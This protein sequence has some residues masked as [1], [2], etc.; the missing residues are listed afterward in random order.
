VSYCS[1]EGRWNSCLDIR[2]GPF[3]RRKDVGAWKLMPRLSRTIKKALVQADPFGWSTS[4]R[5]LRRS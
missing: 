5:W 3:W 1:G 2:G 4:S